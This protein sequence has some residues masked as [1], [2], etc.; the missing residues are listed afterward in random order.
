MRDINIDRILSLHTK[1]PLVDLHADTFSMSKDSPRFVE[2]SFE[3]KLDLPRMF[4]VGLWAEAFSLFVYP[5]WGDEIP[6]K[7]REIAHKQLIGIESAIASSGGKLRLARNST[8][9]LENRNNGAVSAIIEV[10]GLHSLCG[11]LEDINMLFNRGVRIF[12]LT[13][14]NS[15]DWATS[16]MDP[17][18]NSKGLTA[19]GEEAVRKI[20]ALGGLIDFSHSG[21]KT[22]WETMSIIRKPPICTHSCCMSLQTSPRNLTDE[23]ICA[24]IDKQGIIGVNFYPGF[25][26]PKDKSEVTSADIVDHIEHIVSLGGEENVGLGSDFDGVS[27]LPTDISDCH[28]LVNITREMIIRGFDEETLLRVLGGNF[29]R[30]FQ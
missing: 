26:S 2:G 28:G 10:E 18:A 27:Y 8:E 19:L 1:A 13:W 14:N 21:E 15:N 4:E 29:L 23:Q 5:K 22:F 25:L 6:E 9:L 16:C 7:W 24:I 30:V 3:T 17:S 20:D 12:T 11:N